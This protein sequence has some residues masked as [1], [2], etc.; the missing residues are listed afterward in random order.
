MKDTVLSLLK[1]P[2]LLIWDDNG[3][4]GFSSV[5]PFIAN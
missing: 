5:I 1:L 3:D 2:A 4:S